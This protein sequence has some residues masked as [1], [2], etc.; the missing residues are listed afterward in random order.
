MTQ[1]WFRFVDTISTTQTTIIICLTAICF[2]TVLWFAR[3]LLDSGIASPAIALYRYGISALLFFYV[4]PL[5]GPLFRETAWAELAEGFVGLG[6]TGFVE[7]LRVVPIASAS[8]IYMTYPLFTLIGSWL[9]I[10]NVP[11]R[12]SCVAG[13]D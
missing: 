1:H 8:V 6:W 4:L 5:K 3:E 11:S 13:S 2:G 12:K 10:R 9:L 7:A